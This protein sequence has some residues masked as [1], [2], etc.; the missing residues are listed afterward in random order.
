[1]VV[2]SIIAAAAS[3]TVVG[4]ALNVIVGMFSQDEYTLRAMLKS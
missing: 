4:M 1:M 3:A 2:V